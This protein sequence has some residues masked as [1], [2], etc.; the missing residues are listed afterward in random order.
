MVHIT[1]CY[2]RVDLT[3]FSYTDVLELESDH[4]KTV[5]IIHSA[6][7]TCTH[8][9]KF[10]T[11]AT[12]AVSLFFE[13]HFSGGRWCHHKGDERSCQRQHAQS[14]LEIV[15]RREAEVTL[16][17]EVKSMLPTVGLAAT[18]STHVCNYVRARRENVEKPRV[19]LVMGARGV[20]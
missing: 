14:G 13:Q 11:L 17:C 1:A 15:A 19:A 12:V 8:F 5:R 7:R 16:L 4:V 9:V 6:Q 2:S 3:C 10:P 20:L 18:V